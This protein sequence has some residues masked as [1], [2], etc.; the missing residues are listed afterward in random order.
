MANELKKWW[1][2]MSDTDLT[3]HLTKKLKYPPPLVGSILETVGKARE[4]RRADKIR[5][6]QVKNSWAKIIEPAR[7]ELRTVRVM[8]HQTK[9]VEPLDE[10][11]WEAL[12]RYE[13]V[14]ALTIQRVRASQTDKDGRLL[15]PSQAIAGRRTGGKNFIPPNDGEHW[16]DWVTPTTKLEI[17]EL[18]KQVKPPS[19]GKNKEPFARTIPRKQYKA[20]RF[21]LVKRLNTELENAEQ[22]YEMA[23]DPAERTRLDD[24]IQ[25]MHKANYI[26]DT[27]KPGAPLPTTWQGL[28]EERT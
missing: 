18:F 26:L 8:K 11:K 20:Q 2:D 16:T 28:R 12:C 17:K 7:T 1:L 4:Q 14:L 6:T 24:L 19:R 13:T 9:S 23:T 21:A 22:D 25:R 5:A 10:A 27:M 3:N 15:T